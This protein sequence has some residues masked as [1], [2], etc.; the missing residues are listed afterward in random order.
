MKLPSPAHD[1][2]VLLSPDEI[3]FL[4]LKLLHSLLLKKKAKNANTNTLKNYTLNQRV[5]SLL[6]AMFQKSHI[7]YP[8]FVFTSNFS[9]EALV[10]KALDHIQRKELQRHNSFINNTI[11]QIIFTNA[12]SFALIELEELACHQ[13]GHFVY[14]HASCSHLVAL[15]LV[16]HYKLQMKTKTDSAEHSWTRRTLKS[17]GA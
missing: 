1:G 16:N 7:S 17:C 9:R 14:L 2:S 4:F 11:F 13:C 10:K 12:N 6:N 5:L 3:E 15:Y 8:E